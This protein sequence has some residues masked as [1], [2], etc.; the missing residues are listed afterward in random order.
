MNSKPD[1]QHFIWEQKEKSVRNFRPF[2]V[3]WKLKF[4][5]LLAC[6]K[7]LDKQGRPR[8]DC[9][10]RSSLTRVFLVCY[11]DKHFVNYQ[12]DNQH[13]IWE[14][15]EKSVWNFWT[16][17]VQ[18]KLKF[19]TLVACQKCLDKQGR[20]RSDCFFRRSSLI[21]V[22]P[23]FHSKKHL[24]SSTDYQPEREKCSNFLN[25][26]RTVKVGKERK[27]NRWT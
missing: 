2:T 23:V 7:C 27:S 10:G 13:F 22:F 12:P 8:S 15:K 16:F 6:Q 21:R 18:W 3:Q 11:S 19:Q 25:I 24:D 5:T 26:Y 4:Q 17:T 20:P 14:Q 9:F 1:N